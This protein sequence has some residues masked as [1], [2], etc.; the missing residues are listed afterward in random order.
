MLIYSLFFGFDIK[1]FLLIIDFILSFFDFDNIE[2]FSIKLIII[3]NLNEYL[4]LNYS[5]LISLLFSFINILDN[6]KRYLYLM[7]LQSYFFNQVQLLNVLFY[8]YVLKI[9][10]FIFLKIK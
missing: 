2:N 4:F 7:I 8:K 3:S 5:I 6:D 9:R 10:I 1:Y